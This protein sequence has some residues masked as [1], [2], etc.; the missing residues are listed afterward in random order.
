MITELDIVNGCLATMG[1]TPLV[2]ITD[3]HPFVPAARA[4]FRMANTEVSGR[5][6]WFNTDTVALKKTT[7]GFTYIP[8]DAVSVYPVYTDDLTVRGRKLYNRV[9]STFEVGDQLC[10]VVRMLE[11]EDLPTMAKSHIHNHA[12]LGF[13][14]NYDAD[15]LRLQQLVQEK[16]DSWAVLNAEHIRQVRYNPMLSAEMALKI[17]RSG[18]RGASYRR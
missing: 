14:K 4:A 12:V 5:A 18:P 8:E 1:E 15:Q 7:D 13:Q 17:M 2:E 10:V 11:F 16:R 6:W 9:T 3:D